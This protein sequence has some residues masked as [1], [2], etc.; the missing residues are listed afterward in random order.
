MKADMMEILECTVNKKHSLKLHVFTEDEEIHEGLIVCSECLYWHPIRQGVPEILPDYLRDKKKEIAFL[1]KWK[2]KFPKQI[3]KEGKP[4]NK[5]H[6]KKRS[7]S[8]A[9][10]T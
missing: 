1:K 7:K 5:S 4:Y 10:Q 8:R 6:L 3:L 9:S 2:K